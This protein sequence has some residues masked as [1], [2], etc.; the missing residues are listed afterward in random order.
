MIVTVKTQP[1]SFESKLIVFN[2]EKYSL[3]TVI[4]DSNLAYEVNHDENYLRWLE[5]DETDLHLF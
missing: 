4:I 5:S 2:S 1:D 3:K